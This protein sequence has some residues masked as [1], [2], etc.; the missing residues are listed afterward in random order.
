MFYYSSMHLTHQ[1]THFNHPQLHLHQHTHS[2]IRTFTPLQSPNET[3]TQQNY[4]PLGN[5]ANLNAREPDFDIREYVTLNKET[6]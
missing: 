1:Q 6:N 3:Q 5:Q 4:Q 2:E